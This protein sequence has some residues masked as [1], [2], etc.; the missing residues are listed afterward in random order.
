[1]L[2]RRRVCPGEM[3]YKVIQDLLKNPLAQPEF[4]D[5]GAGFVL[6]SPVLN[7][8]VFFVCTCFTDLITG[9]CYRMNV[10]F[11]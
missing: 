3:S 1:M 10:E 2:T 6:P 9:H 4:S 8:P 5:Q 11:G 7:S